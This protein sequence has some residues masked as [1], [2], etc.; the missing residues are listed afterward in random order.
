LGVTTIVVKDSAGLSAAIKAAQSGDV[1]QLA[2]GSYT[3][4]IVGRAFDGAG[5]TITSQD[6]GA[7][8]TL[9]AL[10]VAEASGV[11]LTGLEFS[12]IG[13]TR[14]HPFYVRDSSN[15]TFDQLNVHG[16]ADG[17]TNDVAAMMIRGSKN[18]TVQNSQF[19]DV[20]HG[21]SLLD[22]D[23]VTV[24]GNEFQD[25]QADGVRGGGTSNLL[26][27]NNYF[28]SFH[29]VDGDHPDAIQ[30]WTT[31]TTTSAT[32]ITITGNV[33]VRGAGDPI[34]G[35]FFRDQVGD[36]PFKNVVVTD[37]L[38]VGGAY[39]GLT[40]G[41]VDGGVIARNTV[42]ELPD[43]K[44]WIS[45]P[46]STN[47]T[48]SGNVATTYNSS[49]LGNRFEASN[50]TI[51]T[52]LDGGKAIQSQWLADHGISV[53]R[54]LTPTMASFTSA[55]ADPLVNANTLTVG[56]L[57]A[58]ADAALS[59]MQA[60]IS[61]TVVQTGTAGNDRLDADLSRSNR[62]DAGAGDDI[63]TGGG[64]GRN[65]LVGGDGNDT[66]RVTSVNDQIVEAAGG[67]DDTVVA[68]VNV[69]LS[70][71][72]ETLRLAGDARYGEGNDQANRI[73]GSAGNDTLIGNGGADAITA[74]DGNDSVAGGE[75]DDALNAG[76]GDD[77]LTG[78]AGADKLG[79]EKGN[80]SIAGGSG[81]DYIEGGSGA[82]T[83]SGGDGADTFF[84]RDGDISRAAD[85][86][87]DYSRAQGDVINL[88]MIDAN[89]NVAADQKFAFIGTQ[90]FH[91]VAG[92][93]RYEV[94]NGVAN[95]YGD[96]NGDGAADFQ[97]VMPGV[98]TLT[99]GDFIL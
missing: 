19:H 4:A 98:G 44:S 5:L 79:G 71:N 92:E 34:Q 7:P 81:A 74:G 96:V 39:N 63:I 17:Q 40:I 38:I 6:P 14:E 35:I 80:D 13:A 75:G 10:S 42:V 94:V 50:V 95:V 18:I 55:S 30:L 24:K 47:I 3:A 66:Y 60:I 84:F 28:S 43:Q 21:I 22:N 8:A 91:K 62:I 2:P 58:A 15:I 90:G 20:R 82:D 86:I 9:T 51:Q 53:S 37:N 23:G 46:S 97:L 41:G 70:D 27:A 54:N 36:V 59:A 56:I 45:T 52:P 12:V 29:P 83:V 73:S 78:G 93:L 72:I 77:T 88:R 65:T 11:K 1:I 16:T 31:N 32:N 99:A 49:T 85:W 89:T 33:V 67:G 26:V 87:L 64:L 76:S 68:Y 57:D 48:L 25:I 69:K 61:Q